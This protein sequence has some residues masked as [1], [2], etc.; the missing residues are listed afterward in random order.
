MFNILAIESSKIYMDILER[1]FTVEEGYDLIIVNM[2]VKAK[3][4]LNNKRYDVLI[5]EIKAED[6]ECEIF[7]RKVRES[8]EKIY[9][10]L[11]TS[12]LSL[13]REARMYEHGVDGHIDKPVAIEV[14]K[15]YISR[16]RERITLERGIS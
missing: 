13:K 8:N 4:E 10:V 2:S 6:G 12:E 1:C 3:S 7:L 9:I 11:F 14:L 5:S 15:A 16:I